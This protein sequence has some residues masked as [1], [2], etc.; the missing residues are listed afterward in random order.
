MYTLTQKHLLFLQK[1]SLSVL[2]EFG[3]ATDSVTLPA[4]LISDLPNTEA[5]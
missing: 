2:A 3:D 5:L 1:V 4:A